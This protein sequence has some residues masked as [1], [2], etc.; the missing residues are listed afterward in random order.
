M[1]VQSNIAVRSQPK[2]NFTP[3]LVAI[4]LM[5]RLHVICVQLFLAILQMIGEQSEDSHSSESPSLPSDES[6]QMRR[7]AEIEAKVLITLPGIPLENNQNSPSRHFLLI[8]MLRLVTS[9]LEKQQSNSSEHRRSR[10]SIP[11]SCPPSPKLF[12]I[13][14]ESS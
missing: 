12:A 6:R 1:L 3:H 2:I 10:R 9:S 14:E 8:R 5:Q 7:L 4:F 13:D 11:A